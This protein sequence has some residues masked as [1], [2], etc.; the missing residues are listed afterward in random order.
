VRESIVGFA[1]AVKNQHRGVD[2]YGSP[3]EVVDAIRERG[4]TPSDLLREE[5]TQID[6]TEVLCRSPRHTFSGGEHAST[7]MEL[8]EC[9]RMSDTAAARDLLTGDPMAF[10]SG[11]ASAA[12]PLLAAVSSGSAELVRLLLEAGAGPDGT[13]QFEM[14]PLHWAAV[15]NARGVAELLVNAGADKSRMSW[16]YLTPGE[17]ASINGSESVAALLAEPAGKSDSS[18]PLDRVVDR[19]VVAGSRPS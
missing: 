2:L 3:K 14:T 11:E 18:A 1:F 5:A 6:A 12:V 15:S 17:L 16:F 13:G 7:I 8:L 4:M 10:S 19:M 9:I